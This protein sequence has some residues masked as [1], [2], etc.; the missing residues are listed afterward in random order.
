MHQLLSDQRP[1]PDSLL[2]RETFL[3][4]LPQSIVPEL[5]SSDTLFVGRLVDMTDRV[6]E[7]S[8]LAVSP[9]ST[10]SLS[11]RPQTSTSSGSTFR[12]TALRALRGTS[13]PCIY[14]MAYRVNVPDSSRTRVALWKPTQSGTTTSCYLQRSV[15]AT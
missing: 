3:Q 7:Y 11:A 2:L 6:I 10:P 5:T 4:H 14:L 13:A 8:C 9:V 1:E 12:K 15:A